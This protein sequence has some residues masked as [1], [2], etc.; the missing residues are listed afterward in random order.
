[1]LAIYFGELAGV[2]HLAI[3]A[4]NQ[5]GDTEIY[6]YNIIIMNPFYLIFI[7]SHSEPIP[8]HSLSF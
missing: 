7:F 2:P 3:G 8:F 5:S 1:M 6:S 4:A